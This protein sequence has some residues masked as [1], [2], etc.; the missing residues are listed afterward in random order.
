MK[1]VK[2]L[3]ILSVVASLIGC[4]GGNVTTEG[5]KEKEKQIDEA[6]KKLNPTGERD[7]R[8][9]EQEH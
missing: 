5:V 6:S 8:A 1:F 7:D 4:A 2:A 9:N 3:L